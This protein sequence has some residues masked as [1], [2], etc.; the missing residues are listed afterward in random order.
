MNTF[1]LPLFG[2][3]DPDAMCEED[4]FF[5]PNPNRTKPKVSSEMLWESPWGHMLRNPETRDPRTFPGKKW[6][7]RFRVPFPVF[8]NI[9]VMCERDNVFEIKRNRAI[10][11]PIEFRAMVSL[12][13]LAKNHDCDTMSELSLIGASTCHLIFQTFVKNFVGRY[14]QELVNM[15]QGEELKAVMNV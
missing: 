14:F 10:S 8:E 12:R 5:R 15:P 9:V 1:T 2:L 4:I 6:I 11:I 7:T 3:D 13:I